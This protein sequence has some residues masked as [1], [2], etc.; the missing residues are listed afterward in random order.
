MSLKQNTDEISSGSFLIRSLRLFSLPRCHLFLGQRWFRLSVLPLP[1]RCRRCA[2]AALLFTLFWWELSSHQWDSEWKVSFEFQRPDRTCCFHQPS[3]GPLHE[4]PPSELIIPDAASCW[5]W[6]KRE[7]QRKRT[8]SVMFLTVLTSQVR[9]AER[10][11]G[12]NPLGFVC[13]HTSTWERASRKHLYLCQ[14]STHVVSR[15]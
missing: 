13:F 11:G 1:H 9:A 8:G 14:K 4:R 7:K 3:R 6:K 10:E 5:P 15:P 12:M 2:S